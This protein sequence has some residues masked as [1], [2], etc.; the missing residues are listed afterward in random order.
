MKTL[1]SIVSVTAFLATL[2][3][4]PR[5]IAETSSSLRLGPN[6]TVT[7]A[8]KVS[9]LS[10][11]AM[12][13]LDKLIHEANHTGTL[14]EVQ[15]AAWSDNAAPKGEQELSKYDRALAESRAKNIST[16]I[17]THANVD[18]TTYNMA[19]RANWLARTF[20]TAEAE[21]KAEINRGGKA[22]LSKPEFDVFKKEGKPSSA[23]VLVLLK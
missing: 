21:L 13:K 4:A 12:E 6:A 20:D 2:T 3:L 5:A 15:V 9:I 22:P 14:A 1:Q 8:E 10:P 17:K 18:A 19:E 16:Y 11:E 23:V 7:F